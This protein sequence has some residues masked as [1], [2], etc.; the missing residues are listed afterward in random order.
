MIPDLARFLTASLYLSDDDGVGWVCRSS[1]TRASR[2]VSRASRPGLSYS[3][4]THLDH[5]SVR[6]IH[7]RCASPKTEQSACHIAHGRKRPHEKTLNENTLGQTNTPARKEHEH[8]QHESSAHEISADSKTPHSNPDYYARITVRERFCT[9][10]LG[11][12]GPKGRHKKARGVSPGNA[13]NN[14]QVPEG[15]HPVAQLTTPGGKLRSHHAYIS[16]Q[17][18]RPP[19]LR[20]LRSRPR[21]RR[22][23]QE[24]RPHPAPGAALSGA[25]CATAECRRSCSPRSTASK[26]L[27]RR[28]FRRFRSQSQHCRK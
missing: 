7:T 8:A 26:N 23:A 10:K 19:T 6:P 25:G 2:D 20:R 28:Y 21:R 5:R 18:R 9:G 27:A 1:R 13:S 11:R 14:S 16:L 15:R 17:R 3:A 24:R 12:R 22:T 4:A